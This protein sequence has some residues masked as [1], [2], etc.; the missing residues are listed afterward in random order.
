MPIQ[1]T[2]QSNPSHVH[3][4]QNSDNPVS[5]PVTGT[6]GD[7]SR[8]I[9]FAGAEGEAFGRIVKAANSEDGQ[10]LLSKL[11][12]MEKLSQRGA[13]Y[14]E[15]NKKETSSSLSPNS[16]PSALPNIFERDVESY[17]AIMQKHLAN[18]ETNVDQNIMEKHM[19]TSKVLMSTM[20][21][22]DMDDDE[23]TDAKLAVEFAS[24]TT[25]EE[26][27]EATAEEPLEA[28][29]IERKVGNSTFYV[30]LEDEGINKNDKY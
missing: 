29:A 9:S 28:T 25:A 13:F 16:S 2:S 30:N 21:C 26:P 8:Q 24:R 7:Q 4:L 14:V 27:L 22:Y 10:D 5:S 11:N 3:H 1:G 15:N 19:L 17:G 20:V 18:S 12:K 6:I 23:V